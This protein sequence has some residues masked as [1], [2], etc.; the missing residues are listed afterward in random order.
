MAALAHSRPGA[1]SRAGS[2]EDLPVEMEGRGSLWQSFRQGKVSFT[3]R[4]LEPQVAW[5]LAAYTAWLTLCFGA[6]DAT[7]WGVA[8]AAAAIGFWGTQFPA[9][10]QWL[11][12]ARGL[13]LLTAGFLL[14]LASASGGPAGPAFALPFVVTIV[15][16]LML[17][18]RWATLLAASALLLFT[19]ACALTGV[20]SPRTALALGGAL[21]FFPLLA[22]LY[23]RAVRELD[24]QAE[25]ARMDRRSQ[26]YNETGFFA[27][28]AELFEECRRR[29]RPFSMVLLNSGD[30]REVADLAGKKAAGQLLAQ[31]VAKL[32]AVT[33][34]EGIAARMD[35]VEFALALPGLTA[36]RAGALLRQRLGEPPKVE[37]QSPGG[38]VTVILDALVAEA[39]PE[40]PTLEEF[41]DRLRSRM[42]RRLVPP[43][44]EAATQP[45]AGRDGASTLE[46]LLNDDGPMPHHDRPTMPMSYGNH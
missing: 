6:A 19:V 23:G 45:V 14:H 44:T 40:V 36:E 31:L 7:A 4:R 38:K 29:K 26:L 42:C 21:L 34:R 15:Y 16:A 1:L 25:L 2:S 33:P 37:L 9:H 20:P 32:S 13:M 17:A 12:L 3:M 41:Y 43:A 18:R 28:G 46:G 8:A 30:L 11:M 39:T 27:H 24:R 5:A 22:M 10:H 35:G